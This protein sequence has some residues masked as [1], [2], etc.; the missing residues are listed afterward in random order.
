[1]KFFFSKH[2]FHIYGYLG[3]VPRL[4]KVAPG[5]YIILFF[6]VLLISFSLACAIMITSFETL[7]T[8]FQGVNASG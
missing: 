5:K 7:K 6:F 1:M 4:L 3:L 8:F 2:Y